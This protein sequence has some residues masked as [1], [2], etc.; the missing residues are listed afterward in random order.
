MMR[1]SA[2]RTRLG[3]GQSP[4]SS[5]EPTPNRPLGGQAV[6]DVRNV[7]KTYE[8]G[9]IA[10]HALQG[11]SVRI[12]PG[13]Y[14]AIMGAS[15]SGK[16]TLMNILGCLDLPTDGQYFL[17]GVDVRGMT[18][19]ELSDVRNRKIGFVF[20]SFNLIP[21]TE[22]IVNVEL[23]LIYGGLRS[24]LARRYRAELALGQVGLSDRLGHLPSE[25]SGGQQQRVAVARAL[26][27]N[28][29]LIL[30]DEPTGNLDTKST[31]EVLA[32][33]GQLNAE[34]RTIVLITHEPD[35]AEHA[36]RV[37]R[38]ID[39]EII[40]DRRQ[41]P[42]EGPPPG[43][44]AYAAT[45]EGG[46]AVGTAIASSKRTGLIRRRVEALGSNFENVR[47]AIQGI[48]ANRMRSILTMLGILIGVAAV[49]LVVAVGNGSS[50]AIQAR[51]SGLGT[52]SLT[53]MSGGGGFGPAGKRAGTQSTTVNL[54]QK[55]VTA[56][57]NKT[58]NPDIAAVSPVLSDSSVT[59]S[60]NGSTYSPSSFIG[61]NAVYEQIKNAPV[62]SGRFLTQSD[63]D[64]HSKVVVL[65][66]TAV[67]DLFGSAAANPIGAVVNFGGT[68]LQIIG[69]LKS[70]G[71]NGFQD[72][73]DVAIIPATTMQDHYTGAA[74]GYSQLVVEAT[75]A[76]TATAAE[77]EVTSTLAADHALTSTEVS[78]DF[79]VLSQNQLLSATSS[80]SHT[81]TVLLAAV[82]AI[83][84]LV[85]GIGVMN[86]MLVTVTERTR[87]IGI[88]K[89]IGARKADILGQFLVEA[90]LL[91]VLGGVLGVIGGFVGSHFKVVGI[92]PAIQLYSV[93][94]AFAVALLTG[95]FFGIYPANRAASLRPID[96][97]RY[98]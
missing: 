94:L 85:G 12:D 48:L 39:G 95:L 28:P 11:V 6:I 5:G 13:D 34:G 23:P 55:D 40:E 32:M 71:S 31:A 74:N 66:T 90:V 63:L 68:S 15:G 43:Y 25:L 4:E 26:A 51:L 91:S 69:V 76:N 97:L 61:V 86:I 46:A 87:E 16:S 58:A 64:N 21:R 44:E 10:V 20:Q 82:A 96:A 47:I 27:T 59:A 45:E 77:S 1:L 14:V 50:K 3:G 72:Q 52:N 73:D 30:A 67:K 89:A 22:A 35:V 42:L 70:K 38:L 41:A 19:D 93:G 62:T 53:V 88:R 49:I 98:E 65:G 57:S 24:R 78:N 8:L 75:S 54:T 84:L 17:D 37:I 9:D 81:F 83:S 79:N 56:L 2:L 36:K 18:E 92:K 60:Y 80:T 29:A 7:T 33:F